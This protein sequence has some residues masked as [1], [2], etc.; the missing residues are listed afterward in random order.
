MY[1]LHLHVKDK[2][3]IQCERDLKNIWCQKSHDTKE[4]LRHTPG[5]C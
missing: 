1:S 5:L 3:I 4:K 2:E